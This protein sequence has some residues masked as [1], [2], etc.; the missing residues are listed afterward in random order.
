MTQTARKNAQANPDLPPACA[1]FSQPTQW[2]DGRQVINVDNYVPYFLA[3][4]NNA[5]SRGASQE[6]IECFDIGIVEWRIV[7]MLA[8][9][10]K[11]PASRICEVI[12]L[13]KSSVSRGLK[14]L[15]AK[16]HLHHAEPGR[17]VR[18][19]IW[20]LNDSGYALHDRI[21]TQALEREQKLLSGID[22]ADLEIALRVMRQMRQNVRL[23]ES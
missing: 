23:L 12:A 14:S 13:D 5:L 7:S 16:G 20:W 6:Y 15:L 10:P 2:V 1:R 22:G 18:R 8:I 11:I 19:R 9:E 17:D 3:A 4:I 21:L